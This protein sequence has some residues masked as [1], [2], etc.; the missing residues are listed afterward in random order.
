MDII[1][2]MLSVTLCPSFDEN[3]VHSVVMTFL[4]LSYS[5]ET[6]SFLIRHH[7]F[8]EFIQNETV[9]ERVSVE[10]QELLRCLIFLFLLLLS[11]I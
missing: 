3:V 8:M 2:Q 11:K 5:P 4:V 7:S 6:H 10:I 9:N 1:E